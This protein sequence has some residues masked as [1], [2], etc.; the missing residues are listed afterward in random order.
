LG[1][2]IVL[3]RFL[4]PSLRL[5]LLLRLLLWRQRLWRVLVA[6]VRMSMPMVVSITMYRLKPHDDD[7]YHRVPI[8]RIRLL[9]R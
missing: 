5:W 8:L 6:P 4:L 7:G 3:R 9:I 1:K 2:V